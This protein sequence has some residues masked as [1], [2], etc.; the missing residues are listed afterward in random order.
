MKKKVVYAV[1]GEGRGHAGRGL[2]IARLMQDEI[3]FYFMCGGK[4][5]DLIKS[6]DYNLIEL[7]YLGFVYE[8]N[9]INQFKTL[10]RNVKLYMNRK[11]IYRNI[12]Q[13]LEEIKPDAVICDFEYF[14]P[15]VA[16]K[17]GIP[18]IQ[19]SHQMVLLACRYYVPVSQWWH[20]MLAYIVTRLIINK[21]PYSVGIS[22]FQ[23]P[24]LEKYKKR[25]F[26]LFPPLIRQ[27][28]LNKKPSYDGP[29]LVYFSCNTFGWVVDMLKQFTAEKFVVYGIENTARAD[30]NI[31]YKPIS[32]IT[33][34][35]DLV[36]AKA[37]ITNGGHTLISEA[38]H[39][40][41]P[42][43]AFYVHGQF[44]Q[45][46][47]SYYLHQ[48]NFGRRNTTRKNAM[49]EIT[50]FLEEV[51]SLTEG[52][53]KIDICGN[54]IV[55]SYLRDIIVKSSAKKTVI[56]NSAVMLSSGSQQANRL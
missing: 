31:E 47:N 11:E 33:F 56:A 21:T 44:E 48:L 54:D 8:K 17:M 22:F 20:F 49:K 5:H 2:A 7:P 26:K 35:D 32:P 18:V 6:T 43:F 24:S 10:I 23:L 51:P 28:I 53:K 50:A 9:S 1:S 4:A 41:K 39:L 46:L 52:L 14:V 19:L 15:R 34:L 3:D 55:T 29:I 38:V 25:N 42:C 37:V 40:N 13:K 27:H 36:T 45:Y 30:G 12:R 16:N